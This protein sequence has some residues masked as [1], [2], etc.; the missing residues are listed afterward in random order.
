VK[1][2]LILSDLHIPWQHPDALAFAS[3][4]FQK[5]KCA[6][7]ISVGDEL[8][9]HSVS[10]HDHD[11]DMPSP[12]DELKLARV[13]ISRWRKEFPKMR[14]TRSNHGDLLR[15]R[16]VAG[17]L[18]EDA[19]KA[20]SA[21]YNAP[22]W[23]WHEEIVEDMR[24]VPLIVRHDF[25]GN[26]KAALSKVGD[27]C[28]AWG[29]RH[30]LFGVHYRANLHYKQWAMC[31]GCLIDPSHRAYN[32]ARGTLDRPMLGVG[33]VIDGQAIPVP[34]WTDKN[35]RWTGRAT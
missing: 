30:T 29:H 9:W 35:G 28:I 21:L 1:H 34:M 27:S 19:M 18:P 8:D 17:G 25:G 4:V 23:T 24:G 5:F 7:V 14:I 2:A 3:Y 26:L 20:Y 22:G 13:E 16:M 6:Q 12:G 32:Y 10:F 33:V 11:P 15:R 31:V